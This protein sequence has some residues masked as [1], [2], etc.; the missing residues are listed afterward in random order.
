MPAMPIRKARGWALI[1]ALMAAPAWAAALPAGAPVCVPAQD[2]AAAKD[3]A[4]P[5]ALSAAQ[6][7][8]DFELSVAAVEAALPDLYWHQSQQQWSQAKAEARAKLDGVRDSA[9]LF[10]VLRPLL[11]QIGEGHLALLRTE[12]MKRAERAATAVLPIDI[13]WN[14]SA[15]DADR[16]ASARDRTRAYVIAGYG[17]A[18]TIAPGTRL[19]AIDGEPVAALS[20]ELMAAVG[21]D[22]LN[23]TGP[24][25]AGSGRGYAQIR[26]RMRD[27]QASFRLRLQTA[28]GVVAERTVAAVRYD[29]RPKPPADDASAVATLEWLGPHSAYLSVPSF[30]NGAY[31]KSCA[32]FHATMQTIFE[33]LQARGARDL[34]LDLRRNGGGDEPNESILFSYLVEQPLHKYAAV[35]AKATRLAVASASGKMFET[36]V[37][38]AEDGPQYVALGNGGVTRL[39]RPPE[40]LMSSWARPSPTYRGRLV[41]LAGGDTFSGGAELASMLFHVR[42]GV[43]V[44]EEVGGAHQGNTSGY[45]WKIVLPNSRMKLHVPLLQF[46]MNWPALPGGGGV[47][48]DCPAPPGV[49]E[50]GVVRDRAWRVAAGLLA[51]PWQRPAQ[52][53]CPG[54]AAE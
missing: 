49:D 2:E 35:D 47:R 13:L 4:G 37:L 3:D 7:R 45:R 24:M 14:E 43:F 20:D 54:T 32:N 16:G 52:A 53:R 34:I 10:R 21:H 27:P 5:T 50:V 18:A 28:D 17:E 46:R 11:G 31:E 9:G 12:A 26:N 23:R 8:E 19:L 38:S 1:G 15:A 33:Q 25:R 29:A 41:V 51:Q 22:G 36:E 42:R 44:G 6:A 48:P 40:G 39:N 30:D